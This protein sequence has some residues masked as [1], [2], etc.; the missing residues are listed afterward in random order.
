M[1]AEAQRS[2]PTFLVVDDD[3]MVRRLVSR[4]LELLEPAAVFEVEDGLAAQDVLREQAVDVVVTDVLMPNMDGRELMKW[5]SEN[6]PEPAWIVLSGLDT[7]DAAVDALHLGAFDYLAKPPEVHRVRVAVRNALEQLELVREQKRLHAEVERSNARLAE[8][9]NQLERLCG[10]LEEQAAVI[11]SDLERAEIIQRAL[12]PQ[13]APRINGWCVETLYRSGSNVGGDFYDVVP[14]DNHHVGL[15]VADAAGHGVAAAMLSVLF[16]LRLKLKDGEDNLLMPNRVLRSLNR[17]LHEAVTAPGA[18]ITA[19]YVLLNLRTGNVRIA[20]AGHPPCV[21]A[22]P[23]GESQLLERTGPALGLVADARYGES[24]IHMEVGDRLL[25]YTDGVLDGGP[26]APTQDQLAGVLVADGERGDLL[27]SLYQAATRDMQGDQDD[28]TM[29]LLERGPGVSRFDDTPRPGD[30]GGGQPEP[31]QVRLL[32]GVEAKRAFISIAGTA[33]WVRSQMFLDTA[34]RLLARH[35]NLTIDLGACEY[36]DSTFLGTL[37][38][39]VMQRPDAVHLQQV[40]ARIR[41]LFE[42]LSMDAV[43]NHTSLTSDPLPAE[44]TPLKRDEVDAD[45]QG[46]RMLSAHETLA[47]LSE[48]NRA[49][50]R[51]V[52]ESLRDDLEKNPQPPG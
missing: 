29:I 44:M 35:G 39:I 14:L 49:L 23:K 19:V 11:R 18:F 45:Q 4:G 13:V 21:W 27:S 52:V 7:F 33:T 3:P 46:A 15:V 47:S 26:T 12:L 22:S 36:L 37:H 51:D 1:D 16:K 32:E 5:A 20:S 28:I 8:K 34:T 31:P 38:E 41:G 6:C 25:L 50:F 43:L 24:N 9:V 30:R 48:E 2:G 17:S 40:P 42:E 10:M